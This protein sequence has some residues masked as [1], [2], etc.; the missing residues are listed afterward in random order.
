MSQVMMSRSARIAFSQQV[1]EE[2]LN[3]LTEADT[4]MGI[5][6]VLE[7]VAGRVHTIPADVAP[8]LSNSIAR[9]TYQS[10]FIKGWV[11]IDGADERNEQRQ[12][13]LEQELVRCGG[14]ADMRELM[15]AAA[16]KVDDKQKL[17]SSFLLGVKQ[18]QYSVDYLEAQVSLIHN[19]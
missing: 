6:E 7:I 11:F 3:L 19:A 2:I 5:D 14:S 18:G 10:D 9:K 15:Q 1:N 4:P 8:V 17:V 13:V 12:K 16:Q